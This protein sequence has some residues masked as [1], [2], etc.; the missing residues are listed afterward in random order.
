[1]VAP[2]N[3]T[4]ALTAGAE[5]DCWGSNDAGQ[6]GTNDTMVRQAPTAIQPSWN[7]VAAN[8]DFTV[9]LDPNLHLFGWGN[10]DRGQLGIGTTA[11]KLVPT[12]AAAVDAYNKVY[13]GYRHA[14]ALTTTTYQAHCWGA[15]YD[16]QVGDDTYMDRTSPVAI[17]GLTFVDLGAGDYHTCGVTTGSEV[18]CWGLNRHG[19]LGNDDPMLADQPAPTKVMGLPATIIDVATGAEH[20][21]AMST[22]S[23][24]WCWGANNEGQLGSSYGWTTT[25][26]QVP[27]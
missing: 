14:C 23:E 10:N 16:G 26:T 20:T 18:Y 24:I 15:N 1:M 4:C 7:T 6:L 12:P 8:D 3:H 25:F 13:A 9:G 21:C 11:S 22:S 27:E 5:L 19:Q 17:A 2:G